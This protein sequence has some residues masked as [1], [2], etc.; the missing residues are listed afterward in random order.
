MKTESME[1]GAKLKVNRTQ[2]VSV[3]FR[4]F[5]VVFFQICEKRF[6]RLK[7]APC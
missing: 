2:F 5:F 3:Q 1:P 7:C 4:V 6:V